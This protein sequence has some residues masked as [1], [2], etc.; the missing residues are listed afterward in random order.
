MGTKIAYNPEK[1]FFGNGL[2]QNGKP[3][4]GQQTGAGS[5]KR[6][7]IWM[8]IRLLTGGFRI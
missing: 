1:A 3:R 5:V 4:N 2:G 8:I 6:G 7:C